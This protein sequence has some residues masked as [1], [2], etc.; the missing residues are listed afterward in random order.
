MKS[1]ASPEQSGKGIL[2]QAWEMD[3]AEWGRA[4]SWGQLELP[5]FLASKHKAQETLLLK[6]MLLI[7]KHRWSGLACSP[8]PLNI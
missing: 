4:R 1:R 6:R 7:S 5:S 3:R 2:I 8:N